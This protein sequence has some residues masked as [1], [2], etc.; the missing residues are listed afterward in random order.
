MSA[1]SGVVRGRWRLPGC[2]LLLF[3]C[4]SCPPCQPA[5]PSGVLGACLAWCCVGLL[6][7]VVPLP[8]L[9]LGGACGCLLSV[10][11]CSFVVVS[12]PLP[13]G[14]DTWGGRGR[15]SVVWVLTTS[16]ALFF[17]SLRFC[18]PLFASFCAPPC[19]PLPIF[20][21][22]CPGWCLSYV[23]EW[24]GGMDWVPCPVVG[25]IGR[26]L[27]WPFWCHELWD[28]CYNPRPPPQPTPT[29]VMVFLFPLP[30]LFCPPCYGFILLCPSGVIG[31]LRVALLSIF[32]P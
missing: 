31:C 28:V 14:G 26:W 19:A 30:L 2:C 10:S 21:Q 7:F 12:F 22:L 6:A 3:F 15:L 32:G 25:M 5:G 29:C 4:L 18:V 11:A 17:T 23:W 9:P 16:G 13:T 1:G 27:V 20:L 24:A 8:L